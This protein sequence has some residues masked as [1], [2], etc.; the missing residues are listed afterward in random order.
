LRVGTDVCFH[1]RSP[2][3]FDHYHC[4][5]AVSTRDGPARVSGKTDLRPSGCIYSIK[6]YVP[7]SLCNRPSRNYAD[8]PCRNQLRRDVR[9]DVHVPATASA[10]HHVG[11]LFVLPGT[12]PPASHGHVGR[13]CAGGQHCPPVAPRAGV[14]PDTAGTRRPQRAHACQPP[15]A[16][17]A[18]D[19]SGRVAGTR[20][21]PGPGF[22][23]RYGA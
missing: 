2:I 16:L 17:V 22:G 18:R 15:P 7:R 8:T 21:G 12:A 11:L 10:L 4:A 13:L 3:R 20:S 14:P 19:P 23:P 1:G 6:H 9:A 5:G